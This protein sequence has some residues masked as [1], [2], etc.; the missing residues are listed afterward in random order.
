MINAL[1]FKRLLP[2]AFSLS[3]VLVIAFVL[4]RALPGDPAAYL[5]GPSASSQA[6][7]E[8]R[9]ALGLDRSLPEQFFAYV[10]QIAAGDLGVSWSTGQPVVA[11]L[12]S[13]LPASLE[14]TGLGLL[15]AI[16]VA[17]PLGVAAALKPGTAIDHASRFVT[18]AGVSLPTFFTGLLFVYVFYYELGWFPAPLGRLA[19]FAEPPNDVTGL[20]LVDSLL[21]GDV[22]LFGESLLYLALP[23]LTLGIFALAPIARMTRASMLGV[24][25]SDFVRT[26]RASGLSRRKVL[27]TYA[28][29][30]ALIP[31]VTTLG[32][33]FSY[34]LGAN[35]LV[36]KVFSWPGVGSFA[37]E[38][39]VIS[40]YAAVQG[41]VL[42]MGVLYVLLNLAIDVTYGLI[43]PRVKVAS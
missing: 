26:A 10:R 31:L 34:L 1:F 22:A 7:V 43:D 36:E 33:V 42:C 17:V 15:I 12:T 3:G 14:L 6:V 29:K 2:S 30:N 35:V 19:P 20:Y 9:Q 21:E 11:E 13:R 40:D 18:T 25:S 8:I 38:A 4:T 41:F 23:S 5:A 37:L 27:F 39:L 24:L 28:L 16:A 32:M